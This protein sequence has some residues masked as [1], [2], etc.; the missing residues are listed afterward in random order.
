MSE[1][2]GVVGI[3]VT[4]DGRVLVFPGLNENVGKRERVKGY[5]EQLENA[6]GY[7]VLGGAVDESDAF[8]GE[9]TLVLSL[10]R[11]TAEERGIILSP[12]QLE[13]IPEGYEVEQW[14]NGG[15]RN[16]LVGCY[17]INLTISQEEWLRSN[18]AVDYAQSDG[19]RPR[20]QVIISELINNTSILVDMESSVYA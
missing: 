19:L 2:W 6:V 8:Y 9:N 12:D 16:F 5:Q 14:G 13:M 4:K 10:L 15:L 7:E 20:D 18:G 11:E 17:L 1:K 3:P